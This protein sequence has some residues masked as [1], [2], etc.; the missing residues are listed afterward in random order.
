MVKLLSR[1]QKHGFWRILLILGKVPG[2]RI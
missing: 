1:K 2:L